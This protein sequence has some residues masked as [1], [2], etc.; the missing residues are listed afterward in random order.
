MRK[1]IGFVALLSHI[2]CFVGVVFCFALGTLQRG[3]RAIATCVASSEIV[4]SKRR[5]SP[6]WPLLRP[7]RHMAAMGIP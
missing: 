3:Q 1:R 5:Q 6:T 4:K 7:G 2:N